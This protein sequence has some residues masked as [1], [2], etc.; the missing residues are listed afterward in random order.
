MG[1]QGLFPSISSSF[2]FSSEIHRG[3]IVYIPSQMYI[4][5]LRKQKEMDPEIHRGLIVY[6]C[7]QI[8]SKSL[9]KQTRR[10]IDDLL[11]LFLKYLFKAQ[12][13]RPRYSQRTYCSYSFLDIYQ[14]LKEIG[15]FDHEIHSGLIV[16]I[17]SWMSI[18]S[19]RKQTKMFIDD[20]WSILL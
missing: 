8:S 7:S 5:S 12:G 6:I 18:I 11:S 10:S 14:K 1:A 3:L 20:L 13:N 16:H 15:G 19:L 9:R 4:K 2:S 17:P